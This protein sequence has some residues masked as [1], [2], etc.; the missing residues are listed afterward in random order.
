M[1]QPLRGYHRRAFLVLAIVLPA[2]FV[3]GL[4]ARRKMPVAKV[5]TLLLAAPSGGGKKFTYPITVWSA[6]PK[7]RLI[8]TKP[9]VLPDALVYWSTQAPQEKFLPADAVFLGRLD[10]ALTYQI[11]NPSPG[12]L[13]IYSPAKKAVLDYAAFGVRP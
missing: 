2:V 12:F 7:A 1:I 9:L 5:E 4:A 3:G 11:P 6:P 8:A 13:V 10:P